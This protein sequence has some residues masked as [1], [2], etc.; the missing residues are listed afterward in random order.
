MTGLS[1][2]N[3]MMNIVII[4]FY[5]GIV[6][7]P[8]VMG[9]FTGITDHQAQPPASFAEILRG[10]VKSASVMLVVYALQNW[11][12]V[13]FAFDKWRW[14]LLVFIIWLLLLALLVEWLLL[15]YRNRRSGT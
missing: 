1:S 3:D 9:V 11:L 15:R 7:V 12:R 4:L 5:V 10:N 2:M 6:A 8:I 14:D 13:G